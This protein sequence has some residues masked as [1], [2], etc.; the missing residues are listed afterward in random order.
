MA[1]HLPFV[2]RRGVRYGLAP[3]MTIAAFF[4]RHRW[5]E[6][7]QERYYRWWYDWAKERVMEDPDLRAA[8]GVDF[9]SYPFGQHARHSFHLQGKHWAEAMADLGDLVRDLILPKLDE[10]QRKA[11]EEA[12]ERLVR[13]L[14]EEARANPPPP[15]PEVGRFRHI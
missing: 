8:K 2:A 6:A 7:L 5:S 4:E 9:A 12:H 14:D 11:L 13:E 1:G 3:R 10:A 15:A